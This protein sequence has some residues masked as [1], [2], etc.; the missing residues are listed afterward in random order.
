MIFGKANKYWIYVNLEIGMTYDLLDHKRQSKTRN[1]LHW[2]VYFSLS[3]CFNSTLFS[4]L[5]SLINIF[6]IHYSTLP[7]PV[8][9]V[10]VGDNSAGNWVNLGVH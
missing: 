6:H 10:V 2:H 7:L 8:V 1:I 5:L 3:H 9:V 4:L